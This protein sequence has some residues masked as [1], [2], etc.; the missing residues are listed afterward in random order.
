MTIWQMFKKVENYNAIARLINEKEI[1][2]RFVECWG[3]N[4]RHAIPCSCFHTY[5]DMKHL[6]HKEFVSE[7]ADLILTNKD[8]KFNTDKEISWKD[9]MGHIN[10]GTFALEIEYKNR[11]F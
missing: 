11:W 2:I 10:K 8:W 6:L 3:N 9:S 1:G 4:L 7:Y 5:D